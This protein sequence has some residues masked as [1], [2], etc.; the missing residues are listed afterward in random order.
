MKLPRALRFWT[1]EQ[2][3][4]WGF[5]AAVCIPYLTFL[6]WMHLHHEMWR[7]E[8]HSWTLSRLAQSFGELVTGDRIYEGARW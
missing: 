3:T 7:D 6:V 1:K 2:E 5:T 8:I 4:G